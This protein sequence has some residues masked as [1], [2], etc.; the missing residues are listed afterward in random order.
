MKKYCRLLV[1][2]IIAALCVFTFAACENKEENPV[3][4]GT[5]YSM[6]QA[7]ENEFL[8]VTNLQSIANHQNNGTNPSDTLSAELEAAIKETAAASYR[9]QK[10]L[11]DEYMYPNAKAEDFTIVKYYGTYNNCIAIMLSDIYSGYDGAEW[12]VLV[13]EVLFTYYSGNRIIIW[14][15][16]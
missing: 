2:C 3:G 1:I 10:N 5:F 11:N 14:K 12:E 9:A 13:A 7:Y 15:Q 16:Q 8:T 6:Q 4:D